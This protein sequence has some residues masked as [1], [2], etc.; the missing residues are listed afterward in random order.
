MGGAASVRHGSG[1]PRG[2]PPGNA[3]ALPFA[4]TA[5]CC[6]R[7]TIGRW[8]ARRLLANII[9]ALKWIKGY[10][11]SDLRADAVAGVTV[12]VLLVP[13]G[14]AYA[15]LAGLPPV[16]GLYASVFPLVA[17]ALFGSSRQLAVGPTAVV[18]L[19][20]LSGCSTVAKPGTEQ[21]WDYAVLT[22]LMVGVIQVALGLLRA[23]FIINFVSHAVI[24]GF[25]SGAAVLICLSQVKHLLGL[26]IEGGDTALEMAIETA[27]HV[28]QTHPLTLAVGLASVL[29]VV[30]CQRK[31]RWLPGPLLVVAIGT[32]LVYALGWGD[33]DVKTV[34]YV[35]HGVP[36]FGAPEISLKSIRVLAPVAAVI[37]AIGYME[38]VAL[39]QL[40]AAREKYRVDPT[41][42]LRAIGIANAVSALCS[43]YPVT[44]S[45][46][47][48]AVNYDAG[49][50]TGV[51]SLITAA[52]V[53]PA[54]LFATPLFRYL[55]TAVL[56]AI[57]IV[58]ATKLIDLQTP[59][60]FFRV[61]RADGWTLAL[62]F[63]ATL[64]FG[65]EKGILAGVLFSLGLFIW[66]SAHP[67]TAELGYRPCDHMYRDI[68]RF[69]DAQTC[70]EAIILRVDRSL[71]FANTRFVEDRLR[72]SIAD[73]PEVRWVVLD[74]SGV[75]D[76]G[77]VALYGLE[78]F[79]DELAARDIKVLFAGM[80]GPVRDRFATAAWAE[81]H[82]E[83]LSYPSVERALENIEKEAECPM[84]GPDHS[85]EH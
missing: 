3:R 33:R 18:S 20:V 35:P 8:G 9:P 50:R 73:R 83:P 52:A 36:P 67:H 34:G 51:A 66:R 46:S 64:L 29:V 65:V 41:V 17:Y 62:T 77:A 4:A 26:A 5:Q 42:E 57:I 19:L 12:A 27:Y 38:S 84:P 28:G 63:A 47:R 11:R 69:P 31:A 15:M 68:E 55:P 71:Y 75:N 70:P 54:L 10:K 82:G 79:V 48:T 56:A 23:G 40:I 53:I 74:L 85:H 43:G 58:S 2:R 81:R 30:L 13:Q 16:A 60:Q 21:F 6:A 7:V 78:E 1:R 22:A 14:M 32:F 61:D 76:V 24:S 49:A 37:A 72:E 45:F 80:K 39:V 25:T 44:G 59:R